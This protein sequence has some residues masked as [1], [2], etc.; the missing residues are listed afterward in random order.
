MVVKGAVKCASQCDQTLLLFMLL[1]MF[2]SSVAAEPVDLD[3]VE[4]D[5]NFHSLPSRY[6][7]GAEVHWYQFSIH[8]DCDISGCW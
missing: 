2:N 8:T 4:A 5:F 7:V 1:A 6:S 3:H